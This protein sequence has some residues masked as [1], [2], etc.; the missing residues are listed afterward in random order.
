MRP[1]R[2]AARLRE[3]PAGPSDVRLIVEDLR[4][5]DTFE[6][7]LGQGDFSRTLATGLFVP[8]EVRGNV[9]ISLYKQAT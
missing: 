2:F 5:G 7:S 3:F 8:A 4:T 1:A 6:I 9:P